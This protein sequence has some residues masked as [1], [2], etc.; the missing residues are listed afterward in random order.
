[1]KKHYEFK[2]LPR[3]SRAERKHQEKPEYSD[4]FHWKGI[5][6]FERNNKKSEGNWGVEEKMQEKIRINGLSK[7]RNLLPLASLGDKIYKNPEYSSDFFKGSGLIPGSNFFVYKKKVIPGQETKEKQMK[8][9][10]FNKNNMTWKER[11]KRENR[12]E[13]ELGVEE[14]NKWEENVLSEAN[15]NW[16]DPE[17]VGPPDLFAER[18]KNGGKEV[19][20]VVDNKKK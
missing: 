16:K 10:H 5:R 13:D 4:E 6:V 12:K 9:V 15:P 8:I 2:P 18:E 17:K 11:K 1:M 7:Q 14:L 3:K 20:K 19:K